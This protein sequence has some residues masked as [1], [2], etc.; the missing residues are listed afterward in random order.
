LDLQSG[1]RSHRIVDARNLKLL[2][3]QEKSLE[4]KNLSSRRRDQIVGQTIVRGLSND[5]EQNEKKQNMERVVNI[6]LLNRG[7]DLVVKV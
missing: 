4:N 7:Q 3:F 1:G 5:S 2:G 6:G